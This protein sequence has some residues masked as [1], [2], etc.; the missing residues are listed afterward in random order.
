MSF[1]TYA[2][3]T[4]AWDRKEADITPNDP[5]SHKGKGGEVPFRYNAEVTRQS[6]DAIVEFF[7]RTLGA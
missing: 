7:G 2:G 4:H 1:T 6:T 5:Y 3:A